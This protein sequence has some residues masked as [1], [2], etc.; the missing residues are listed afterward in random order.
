MES[1]PQVDKQPHKLNDVQVSLLRMFSR[2]MTE[3]ETADVKRL[4]VS[5]YDEKLQT[6]IGRVETEKGYT[7]ADYNAM[8]NESNRT[9]MNQQIMRRS[10]EGGY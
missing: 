8:L 9:V 4:L 6:E 10:D 1:L 2:D 5:Y 7:N 3:Q